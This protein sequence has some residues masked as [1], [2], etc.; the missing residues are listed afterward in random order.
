M[1]AVFVFLMFC[2]VKV[3]IFKRAFKDYFAFCIVLL[4][5]LHGNRSFHPNLKLFRPKSKSFRPK[6][7]L[8]Y[9]NFKVVSFNVICNAFTNY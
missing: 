8:L 6:S 5:F 1:T 7:K 9:P 4:L 3:G 2:C